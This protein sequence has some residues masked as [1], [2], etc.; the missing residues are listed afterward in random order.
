MSDP[1]KNLFA[2]SGSANRIT[3]P[4]PVS[5]QIRNKISDK[6]PDSLLNKNVNLCLKS[7]NF[8]VSK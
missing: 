8:L 6:K 5:E 2:G 4:D 7:Y 3:D 1:V